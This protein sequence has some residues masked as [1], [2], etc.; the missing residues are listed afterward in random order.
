MKRLALAFALMLA[1]LLCMPCAAQETEAGRK[2]AYLT[3]DDG[4]NSMT[5]QLLTV[6]REYDAPATFFLV[7]SSVLRCPEET[8]MILDAGHAVGC[9]SMYHSMRKLKESTGYV[10]RDIARF[11]EAMRTVEPSFTTDLY[12]FPGGST[13]YEPA[14]RRFVRDLGFAWFDWNASNG[15]AETKY[16]SD[17]EMVNYTVKSIEHTSDSVIVLMHE[18]KKRTIRVLP[19]VIKYLRD[20]GYE[21]RALSSGEEERELLAACPARLMFPGDELP[22]AKE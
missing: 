3:F 11:M 2:V 16:S 14:T 9:H 13:S 6:L 20:N 10:E 15:D 19:D 4:P 17:R 8:R 12:R 1:V 21:L 18:G 22:G 5:P 7:G